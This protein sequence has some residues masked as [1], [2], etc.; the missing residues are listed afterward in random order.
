MKIDNEKRAFFDDAVL[1]GRKG[2]FMRAMRNKL[3]YPLTCISPMAQAIF[4]D[5]AEDGTYPDFNWDLYERFIR[6]EVMR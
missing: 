5:R 2:E 1:N 3:Y 4:G 6:E